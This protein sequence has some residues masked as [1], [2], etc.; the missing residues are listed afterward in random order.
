[1][2]RFQQL[3]LATMVAVTAISAHSQTAKFSDGVI[4]IGVMNDRSGPYADLSGEG[5]AIAARMAAEEFGNKVRGVPVEIVTADHQNKADIGTA[6]ARK[7]FDADGVDVVVDI[8]NSAVSLAVNGLVKDRK[9]LVLHNSASSELT[10]KAC[11]SRSVQWQYNAYAASSNVVSKDMIDGGMNTFFII[12]VDYALGESISKTFK[13]AV[14][15]LGGKIVGEVK[16][17]LN[18]TDFSSYLLQAQASGAKAVMLANAGTDLATAARQAREFGLVPKVQLLAAALTKD[19]IKAAG[20][21]VMQGLQT[22]SWYEMYRDDAAKAWGNKFAARNGGKVPTEVQAATYSSVR[23]YLKAIET[24]GTDDADTVMA[25][26]REMK[27]EDAFS[28]NG[29][30]RPDGVMAHDMYLVRL[31]APNQSAGDGDYS[32][33]IRTVRGDQANVP[34]AQSECPLV[35][36]H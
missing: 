1:M 35:K 16:H 18:A 19:V 36:K 20:L 32:N 34:L 27:I 3:M 10:G 17:P 25:K 9:K 2:K 7:W 29:H 22:M 5:S 31:K 11:N 28:A 15:R 6:I 4:R 33:I 21:N 23:S 30:V 26:M 24:V 8:A 12:A 14:E 13:A